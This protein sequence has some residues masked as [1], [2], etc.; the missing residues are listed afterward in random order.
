MNTLFPRAFFFF[1]F[2][3]VTIISR[4]NDEANMQL[5]EIENE[6]LSSIEVLRKSNTDET[7]QEASDALNLL[8]KDAMNT[9]GCFSYPFEKITG[10]AI[11]DSPD[12]LVRLFNWNVP[13]EGNTHKYYC[14]V[15]HKPNK[16]E[17]KINLYELEQTQIEI[18][19]TKSKYLPGNNWYGALYYKIIPIK[20]GKKTIY[21]LMGWAGRDG[22]TT[23]K[24][25][26]AMQFT[27]KGIRLGAPIF[28]TEK[29]TQKRFTLEY[30]DDVAVS[31]K[32]YEKENRIIFDHLS[33]RAIGLEGQYAFYGPDFT[34][35]AF[36]LEKGKWIIER[37]VY[38]TLG[39]EKR[40]YKDPQIK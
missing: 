37:D 34:Y 10:M 9:E 32:Y 20:S 39:K 1:A 29:G 26:D 36:N 16:K 23:M 18:T 13:Q 8:I 27:S 22:S 33:P 14:H 7:R 25:L 35:D 21:S 3:M 28:K 24:L 2:A 40:P 38:V 5:Q 19:A 30:A 17:D 12:Q 11:V 4:G 6:M 31:L 15:M